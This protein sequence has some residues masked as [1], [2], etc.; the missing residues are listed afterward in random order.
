V[1]RDPGE[2]GGD[3]VI[4]RLPQKWF[5]LIPLGA[6]KVS[7]GCVIDKDEYPQH[8]RPPADVFG[9]LVQSCAVMRDRM[10]GAE[11][12]RPLEATADFSYRNR[13]LAG[14]RVIRVGDAAGFMDPIFSAGVFL[15]MYT[16]RMAALIADAALSRGDAGERAM[17]GY[18]RR[19]RRSL[20]TYWRMV[21]AFYTQSFMEL[22]FSPTERFRLTS[23]VNAILAGELDG[24]WRLAWRL[25]LFFLL[26]RLQRRCA[27]V[28]RVELG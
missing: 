5:W 10:A 24:G 8:G 7:V 13:Q 6:D 27:L 15:A 2:R 21:E 17:E 26:A 11:L 14:G 23:A 12:L 20:R 18:E 19:V 28:P 3:T 4:V 9:A 25:Q 22:F 16:G 1:K